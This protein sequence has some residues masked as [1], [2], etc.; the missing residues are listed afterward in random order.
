MFLRPRDAARE[1]WDGPRSGVE[2]AVSFFGADAAYPISQLGEKL[3]GM[4]D[5]MTHVLYSPDVHLEF[6]HQIFA[7]IPPENR[8]P[9]SL[10]LS[11][12]V[13]GVCVSRSARCQSCTTWLTLMRSLW[14]SFL[15]E[16]HG[17]SSAVDQVA[18][19]DQRH[20]SLDRN[21]WP[22]LP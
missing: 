10:S 6:T 1:I 14:A 19:R 4:V 16:G 13:I 12:V 15:S 17:A 3:K 18:C 7:V 21:Q 2:G 22:S 5:G 9:L 8:T 20:A 11:L